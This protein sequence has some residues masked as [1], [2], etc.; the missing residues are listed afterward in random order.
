MA[1]M[2]AEA[3]A[4]DFRWSTRNGGLFASFLKAYPLLRSRGFQN[5]AGRGIFF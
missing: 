3:T 5:V 4:R 1:T 2:E